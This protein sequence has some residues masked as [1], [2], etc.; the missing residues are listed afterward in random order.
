VHRDELFRDRLLSRAL[1]AQLAVA[2]YELDQFEAYYRLLSH[3]NRKIN[4]TGLSLEPLCDATVD[5]LFIEPLAVAS[6]VPHSP[7]E[8]FDLGS[9]G[10]SP[11]LPLKVVRPLLKLTMV[12][13]RERKAAFLR[14]ATRELGMSDAVVINE[15]IEALQERKDLTGVA[16]LVTVRAVRRDSSLLRISR[17]LLS[18]AGGRLF[19]LGGEGAIRNDLSMFVSIKTVELAIGGGSRLLICE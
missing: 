13:T 2:P 9:G 1:R 10:G 18:R 3:W 8:W 16:S 5:R 15:R 11:A 7:G 6:H 12:E 4:L 19:L 14:E 17:H